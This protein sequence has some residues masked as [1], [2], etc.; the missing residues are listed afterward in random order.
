MKTKH[1][2]L[3]E[4]ELA[5]FYVNPH[6]IEK[7]ESILSD[8]PGKS[9]GEIN[10]LD[11]GC[12]RGRSVAK[13]REKGFNAFGVDIDIKTMSNGFPL[14]EQRGL[15]PKKFLINVDDVNTFKDGFFH[16][17]FSE[18]VFEHVNDLARVIKE[19]ERL[20]VP[21]GFGVHCF[22][23]AKN[24]REGHLHMPFVHWFPKA[25]IRKCW[26]AFMQLL[27]YGPKD[28]WPDTL[29][30]S[31]WEAADVYYRYMNEKTY[32]RDN[33][34]IH[35]EFQ[36][37]GFVSKHECIHRKSFWRKILPK[38]FSNNGFPHGSVIFT[39]MKNQAN[40]QV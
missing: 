20:T 3:T 17:I 25:S 13:L 40:Y 23:G 32:Y 39:V 19:H 15:S 24:I 26:I 5:S 10:V 33:Q 8:N 22:P 35:R 12:G 34:Y 4:Q 36:K 1:D 31:Y 9:P 16:L 6:V 7:I 29:N 28:P 14:F 21:G 30:R 37:N 38:Y 11:W 18:Q 27:S 2:L